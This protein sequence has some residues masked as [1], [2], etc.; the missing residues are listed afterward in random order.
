MPSLRPSRRSRPRSPRPR[1]WQISDMCAASS[2]S[3]VCWLASAFLVLSSS[4]FSG[5]EGPCQ[6][7]LPFTDPPAAYRNKFGSYKTLIEDSAG[8]ALTKPDQWQK[9]RREL[10][11]YWDK[12]PRPWPP[13]ISRPTLEI[14]QTTAEETFTEQRVRVQ[15]AKD[16][17]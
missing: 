3:K 5:A 10:F 15:I 17:T 6:S 7:I 13:L 8:R 9:R 12:L 14:L 2:R 11:K 4:H 16:Q 1:P